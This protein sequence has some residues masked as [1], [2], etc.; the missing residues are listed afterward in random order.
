MEAKKL[1]LST[2]FGDVAWLS[3]A[4]EG[5]SAWQKWTARLDLTFRHRMKRA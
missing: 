3:I 2:C 5:F 1:G 4:V